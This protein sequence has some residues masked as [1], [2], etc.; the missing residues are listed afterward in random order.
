MCKWQI[1]PY[2]CTVGQIN[3]NANEIWVKI[4]LQI[5]ENKTLPLKFREIHEMAF[6]ASCESWNWDGIGNHWAINSVHITFVIYWLRDKMWTENRCTLKI[7]WMSYEEKCNTYNAAPFSPSETTQLFLALHKHKRVGR[8]R[9]CNREIVGLSPIYGVH[10]YCTLYCEFYV[11]HNVHQSLNPCRYTHTSNLLDKCNISAHCF[12]ESTKMFIFIFFI[13]FE[14]AS[15]QHG[16][17]VRLNPPPSHS[18]RLFILF[19]T[20]RMHLKCSA[21]RNFVYVNAFVYCKN[22]NFE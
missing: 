18:V 14:A 2:D 8:K 11:N 13:R 6:W 22:I 21:H 20:I 3:Q 17:R 15:F 19:R 9:R 4:K 5:T 1:D 16:Q 12:C 7:V 10:R